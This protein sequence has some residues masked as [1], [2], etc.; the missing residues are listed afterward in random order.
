MASQPARIDAIYRYPVKGLS[1]QKLDRV[2]LSPGQT[3]P[4]DRLYA[5]EN[6]PTGFDPNAPAYF[7]KTRFLMLMRNER[8]AALRTD[9]DEASH[10]LSIVSEGREAA[11]GD[12]LVKG[13]CAPR[14]AGWR[15]RRFSAASCQKN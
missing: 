9:Y 8:L 14:K 10:T 13:I 12:F 4:H 15:S 3:V 7:P 11:R 5:I 1:P 2:A 6:G